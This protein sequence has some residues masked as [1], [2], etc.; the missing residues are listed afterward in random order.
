L[1]GLPRTARSGSPAHLQRRRGRRPPRADGVGASRRG[2]GSLACQSRTRPVSSA[3]KTDAP[4]GSS[5]SP[6]AKSAVVS[7]ADRAS[8][9]ASARDG[10]SSSAPK[11]RSPPDHPGT[12]VLADEFDTGSFGYGIMTAIWGVGTVVG[13]VDGPS[14]LR[15]RRGAVARRLQLARRVDRLRR[16]AL[17]LVRARAVLV[18]RVR[19]DRWPHPGRRAEPTP[20][21]QPG[22]RPKP[23]D[24]R[25]GDVDA[26]SLVVA[27]VVAPGSSPSSGPRARMR[28]VV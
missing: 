20:E 4:G 2:H 15:G 19:G 28:S 12:P 3:T 10:D 27:L 26:R 25:V 6:S 17:A 22:C 5:A 16:R 23:G 11:L 18:V 9:S 13:D 7:S 8:R 1:R 14:D 24:G 21:A